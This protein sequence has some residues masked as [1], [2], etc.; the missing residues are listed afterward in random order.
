[1]DASVGAGYTCLA[2]KLLFLPVPVAP[3]L[4][5]RKE[6]FEELSRWE[7]GKRQSIS[8]L[9]QQRVALGDSNCPTVLWIILKSTLKSK[10]TRMQTKTPFRLLHANPQSIRSHFSRDTNVFIRSKNKIRQNKLEKQYKCIYFC[11]W[12]SVLAQSAF[13]LSSLFLVLPPPPHF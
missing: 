8:A 3:G 11:I 10:K 6:C 5:L 4:L 2:I 1:M 13:F 7:L 12:I 9:S